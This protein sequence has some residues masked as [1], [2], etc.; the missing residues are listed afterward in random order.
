M[1]SKKVR[2]SSSRSHPGSTKT[3]TVNPFH[4][5]KLF[6]QDFG[7]SFT[8]FKVPPE[9]R[10]HNKEL[11]LDKYTPSSLADL[12]VHKKK[13]E[14]VKAWFEERMSANKGDI[15]NYVLLITGQSGVGKS[16]TV[17]A[18]A[19]HLRATICEWNTPTPTIWQEHIHTTNSG[20]R[21]TSKL[22]EF[23][24]FVEKIRKYGLISSSSTQD[25]QKP[26]MILIDDLPVINGKIS[27]GRLQRCLHLLVG[28]VRVPT[29]IL[30]TDYSKEDTGD[31]TSRCWEDLQTFL[32]SVGACK[33][34][35]NPITVN[36]IAKVLS[37]I[38]KGEKVRVTPD[39]INVI[40]KASGGDIRHA[41]TSL[42]YFSLKSGSV[43]KGSHKIDYLDDECTLPFGR[44]E[45]LSLFHALGKFLHNKRDTECVIASDTDSLFLK[46]DFTRLP[47]KMDPPERVLGQAHG[48]ARHIADFLHENFLD[49]VH[50]E[51]MD[52]AWVATSYL[53]D[54]DILLASLTGLQYN[55]YVAENIIQS[56][57]AS[58]AVRG[59][60]FGNRH[61]LSSRW[62]AI[63]RP[64]LWQV[65]QSLRHN[66]KDMVGQRT[67]AYNGVNVSDVS[68]IA[69]EWNPVMR[70]LGFRGFDN[71]KRYTGSMV[72]DGM[73]IDDEIEDW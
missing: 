26:Y 49:F 54:A 21:Y 20:L 52:D 66:K 30:I 28:C 9:Y 8:G 45:T 55:N 31:Y 46:D 53:S 18:I 25:Q 24:N 42:Q 63:R 12:C 6:C 57:A 39:Q 44:D 67:A 60:M 69:T 19:S 37:K 56:T 10:N 51:A 58:V 70:W 59:V 11:W 7:E 1:G 38:C 15:C 27:Y 5:M 33:V 73:E 62:H 29:V 16:A 43:E 32:Q 13:V 22:D 3:T 68:V 41:I 40:A 34:A 14:E 17:H 23:E 48:Q 64:V 61:P 50:D 36:S 4:E 2:V 71:D 47:M 72:D 35:F 65:D